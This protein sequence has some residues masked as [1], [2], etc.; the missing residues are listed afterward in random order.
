VRARRA[1]LMALSQEDYMR[2]YVGDDDSL[3]KPIP[4][5]F[6]PG[7]PLYTEEGGDIL[8]GPRKLDAAKRLLG[9]SRYAGEPVTLLAAQD[10]PQF[11]AW[12][13]VTADLLKRLGMKVDLAAVDWGTVV[14]RRAQKSEPRQGGW[15]MFLTSYNGADG[16]DPTNGFV[17]ANG[18]ELRNGWANNPQIEAEIAAWYNATSLDEEKTIVGR[19]NRLAV[20]HVLFAPLGVLL[21]HIAWRKNV[22]GIVQA[23]LPL[24][25]GVS[26]TA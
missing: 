12:G 4:G 1:I 5:Y 10:I 20:D 8:K 25:W 9:E 13:E 19:L 22:S 21:W 15:H 14:A 23:P 6:P 26:K 3:W 16:A 7:T 11:K 18:N 17:R 24:F 2:A